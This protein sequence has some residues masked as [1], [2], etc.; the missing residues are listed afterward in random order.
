MECDQVR[1]S[2]QL[3]EERARPKKLVAELSLD[4]AI[5][6]DIN[7]KDGRPRSPRPSL[8]GTSARLWI[9]LQATYDLA[10]A[11]KRRHAA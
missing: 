5:P 2:K 4:E 10:R 7:A 11:E 1:A 8:R 9:N 6:Q 3:Q